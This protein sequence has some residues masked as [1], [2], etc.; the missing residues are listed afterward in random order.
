MANHPFDD[1]GI[2]LF[3]ETLM[4]DRLPSP[5][6]KKWKTAVAREDSL[7]RQTA[8]AIAHAMKIWAIEHGATQFSH[9]FQPLNGTTAENTI[10]SWK[11]TNAATRSPAFREKP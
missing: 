6:F 4:R 5:I 11:K 7:D 10:A 9:W 2:H 3:S 8:D 1:F